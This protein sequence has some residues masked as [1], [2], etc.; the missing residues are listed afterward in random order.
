[1]G[2]EPPTCLKK[3]FELNAVSGYV[4]ARS[5]YHSTEFIA[6]LTHNEE[7]DKWRGTREIHFE[8]TGAVRVDSV[9]ARASRSPVGWRLDTVGNY[10]V[11]VGHV[12][13]SIKS[14]H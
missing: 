2:G 1:M 6:G 9:G 13:L 7:Q 4:G 5:S 12:A 11:R 14:G 3:G 8:L 10:V